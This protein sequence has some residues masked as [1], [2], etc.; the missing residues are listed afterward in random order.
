MSY[1]GWIGDDFG[2]DESLWQLRIVFYLPVGAGEEEDRGLVVHVVS[3]AQGPVV[4]H[5]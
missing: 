1:S 2:W 4:P 5:E 3:G